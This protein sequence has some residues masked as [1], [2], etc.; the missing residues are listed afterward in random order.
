[1]TQVTKFYSPFE[2]KLNVYSHAFG[3]G[4]SLIATIL[5]FIKSAEYDE[6]FEKLSLV[7]F[8][9]SLIILFSAST[10]YHSSKE[11]SKL[12]K[13]RIFD[14]AAI[15]L[16]IAGTYS[17]FCMITLERELGWMIFIIAWS[18]AVIGIILKIFFT[19][20]FKILSTLMYI[21]MGWIIVFV[22]DSLV[23]NLSSDGLQ[24]LFIGGLFYTL[25]AVLYM[26]KK[27]PLNHAIFHFF[28]L[29][30]STCHFISIYFYI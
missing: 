9:I 4:L 11:P 27:L 13:L 20:R 24:W 18:I 12:T 17:P 10:I 6:V 3:I 16:L 28:V 19:G 30:G 14:H 22:Y 15:Y 29:A 7:L 25:G 2:E 23:A 5:L 26:I 21:G 8:S 1:M